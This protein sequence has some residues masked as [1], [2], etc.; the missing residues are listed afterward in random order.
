MAV[1]TTI[2]LAIGAIS[3]GDEEPSPVPLV[4]QAVTATPTPTP[5]ATPA[6]LT[7]AKAVTV[8]GSMAEAR[9]GHKATLLGDGRVL[10]TAGSDTGSAEVYDPSTG[11]WSSTGS[12]AEVRAFNTATLLADGRVLVAGGVGEAGLLDS[13]EMYDPSTGTWS[14]TGTM[15]EA[16]L[17]HTA[18][19][20]A[21][22]RVLVTRAAVRDVRLYHRWKCTTRRPAR[23]PQPLE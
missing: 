10:V 6:P 14:S 18:T 17:Y 15:T 19:L 9:A 4:G 11:M 16:R 2:F 1:G 21:D 7:A 22:G 8:P 3:C 13:A 5:T 23:G 12:I 20:L